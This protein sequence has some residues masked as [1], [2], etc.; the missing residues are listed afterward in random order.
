MGSKMNKSLDIK[1]S[2]K[3]HVSYSLGGL[4]DNFITTAF[5]VRVFSYY[6]TEL[7][8]PIYFVSL[9]F[10][11]YGLWNMVNDPMAGYISDKVT[12]FIKWGRRFPFFIITSIPCAII[13]IFIFTAPI[14]ENSIIFLWLLIS[15]CIFDGLFSF[16][17]VNWLALFPYKFRF[18]TE[19]TKVG[20]ITT[21]L[22]QVGLALGMLIPPIFISYGNRG[23]YTISALMVSII[24]LSCII[25]MI[26]GMKE[27]KEMIK[28]SIEIS[29]KSGKNKTYAQTLK[30]A[31]RQKNFITY[32]MVYL[33]Q[34]VLFTVLL[35]SLPY[36][37]RY[38]LNINPDIEIIISAAVLLGG[39]ASVPL[40]M[41]IGRK[42]GNRIGY[43]WGTLLTSLLLLFMLLVFNLIYAIVFAA[44]IGIAMGGTW[45]LMYP[46]FADVFDEIVLKTGVRNEGTLVG[47]RTFFGRLSIVIQA[48]GFVIIH[49]LTGFIAESPIQTIEAQWGI[50]FQT[51][52]IPFIFYFI[53]FLLIWKIYDLKLEKVKS[54]QADL[55]KL[56]L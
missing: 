14:G 56:N 41:K 20:A 35:A 6:E 44:L 33:A 8:L 34:M 7:F 21:A 25:F 9:A 19:R 30:F 47:I 49:N 24:C 51:A 53:A 11:L 22:G 23:S 46:T 18:N 27:D 13:Y 29:E 39:L 15:I 50:R 2:T 31:F 55:L 38:I 45:T 40:W 5:S 52:L 42:Y 43:L 48:V 28:H 32:L 17:Q 4:F 10:V 54:I 12:R 1:Y 26:P 36:I 16:F 3:I 37:V